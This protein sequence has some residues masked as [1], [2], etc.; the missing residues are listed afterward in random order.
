MTHDLLLLPGLN[1][2]PA[3]FD[4]VCAALPAAIRHQAIDLPALDRVEDLAD[5]VLAD[6]PERFWL[7]GFSFGGYVSMAILARAPERVQGLALVCSLPGADTPGQ[8]ARRQAAIEVALQGRYEA[9]AVKILAPFHP[10]SLD[11]PDLMAQRR[12]MIEGYGAARH[13]AHCKACIARADRTALLDGRHPLLLVTASHDIVVPTAAVLGL[14]ASLQASIGS[15]AERRGPG[16]GVQ[17]LNIEGAG[18]LLPM[19]KPRELAAVLADWISAA[20]G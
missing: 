10:D 12:A 6:A 20:S 1:N 18:H 2:T 3:V 11:K 9:E 19:E 4:G 17:C 14:G 7:A 8:I 5:H 13:I 16:G 15:L